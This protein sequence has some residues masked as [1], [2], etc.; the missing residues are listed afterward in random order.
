M[1]AIGEP[2]LSGFDPNE[3]ANDLRCVG[4]ELVQ[5]LDGKA[6]WER[7]A[8]GSA[9]IRPPPASLHIVLARKS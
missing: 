1:A 7:Y 2:Y 6:M 4:L 5:D 8:G 3:V 9:T